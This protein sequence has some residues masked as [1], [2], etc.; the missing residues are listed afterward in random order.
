MESIT[1]RETYRFVK[2]AAGDDYT[3]IR[4][5]D[6]K[7]LGT[8]RRESSLYGRS[9]GRRGTTEVTSWRPV[10]TG[11]AATLPN[12]DRRADAA[13]QLDALDRARTAS[14][15]HGQEIRWISPLGWGQ[16]GTLVLV[17]GDDRQQARTFEVLSGG[18]SLFVSVSQVAQALVN[19]GPL[20]VY[21]A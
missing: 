16:S 1:G 15:T 14:Y 3:V 4:K 7:E 2:T 6:G 11:G 19:E 9:R 18:T 13:V 12:R 8:V 21:A 20:P 17:G 10:P 5:S